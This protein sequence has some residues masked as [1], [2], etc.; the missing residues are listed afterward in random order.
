MEKILKPIHASSVSPV[1]DMIHLG[2]L[3]EYSILRNLHIRYKNQLIYV[4]IEL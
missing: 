2:D 1:H 4:G 3:Q